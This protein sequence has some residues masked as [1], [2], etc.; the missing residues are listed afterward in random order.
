MCRSSI[1]LHP[2]GR[3]CMV[4]LLSKQHSALGRPQE[5]PDRQASGSRD[6]PVLFSCFYLGFCSWS[7]TR[8]DRSLDLLSLRS[9]VLAFLCSCQ[10]PSY[11]LTSGEASQVT[12]LLSS[13]H[14]LSHSSLFHF[15]KCTFLSASSFWAI[16]FH[17]CFHTG[18]GP[19]GLEWE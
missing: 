11:I 13:K 18:S 10:L 3:G 4:Q 12:N 15:L 2:M 17:L 6:G 7:D 19:L 16:F 9:A 14:H 5:I 8:P 1:P